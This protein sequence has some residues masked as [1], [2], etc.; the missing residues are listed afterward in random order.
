MVWQELSL[1]WDY[2][3]SNIPQKNKGVLNQKAVLFQQEL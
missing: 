1:A 3:Y 2:T